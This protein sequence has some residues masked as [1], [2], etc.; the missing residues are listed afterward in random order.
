MDDVFKHHNFLSVVLDEDLRY[1]LEK[2]RSYGASWKKSGGRSAW[3][4]LKRKIDRMVEI[5]REVQPARA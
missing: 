4:M 5:Y 2:D 1:V 3:F